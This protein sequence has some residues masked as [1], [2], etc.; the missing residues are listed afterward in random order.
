MTIILDRY[1]IPE[2]GAFEI[3]AAVQINVTAIQAQCLVNRFL[4]D[5]VSHLLVAAAPDL[6][7]GERTRWRVPVWIGFPGQGRHAVGV[8]EIDTQTGVFIDQ[9]LHVAEIKQR[10]MTVAENL[11]PFVLRNDVACIPRA[12]A[13]LFSHRSS[14]RLNVN[15]HAIPQ[16][17]PP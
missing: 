3:R 1:T 5:E 4:M 12:K 17:P 2:Q 6:V 8:L 15:W 11:P 16:Y 14:T 10:A 13:R 9:G 7:V